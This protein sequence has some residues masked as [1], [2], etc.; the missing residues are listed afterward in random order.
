[1]DPGFQLNQCAPDSRLL[2]PMLYQKPECYHIKKEAVDGVV[3]EA[4]FE[5]VIS[6]QTLEY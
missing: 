4:L 6:E 3:R 2:N 5:V 1:M